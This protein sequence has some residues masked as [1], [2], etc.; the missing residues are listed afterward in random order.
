[1]GMPSRGQAG[2]GMGFLPFKG[3]VRVGMGLES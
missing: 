3:G 2:V 1:M